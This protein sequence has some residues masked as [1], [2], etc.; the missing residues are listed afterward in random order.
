MEEGKTS[1]L[2]MVIAGAGKVE[3]S[4]SGPRP[5]D[6]ISVDTEPS[7]SHH[8]RSSWIVDCKLYLLHAQPPG[9]LCPTNTS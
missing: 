6:F 4:V 5:H 8:V 1:L 2:G 9:F 7:A 3:K